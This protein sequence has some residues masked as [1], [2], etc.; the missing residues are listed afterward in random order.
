MGKTSMNLRDFEYV[1]FRRP[2]TRGL[3]GEYVPNRPPVTKSARVLL[4]ALHLV[5]FVSAGCVGLV[6]MQRNGIA[7]HYWYW[8]APIF[9][10]GAASLIGMMID[11]R[12]FPF[13]AWLLRLTLWY[14]VLYLASYAAL[15]GMA[16]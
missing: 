7:H 3:D 14:P 1:E 2:M 4:I 11:N 12:W 10:G 13:A 15:L 5:C 6:L 8:V 16:H 9:I